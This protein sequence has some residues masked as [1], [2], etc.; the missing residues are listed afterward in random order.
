MSKRTAP[1]YLTKAMR[2]YAGAQPQKVS[3]VAKQYGYSSGCIVPGCKLPARIHHIVARRNGGTNEL[4]NLMPMCY[5][6]E[7]RVH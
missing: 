7:S 4:T 1:R 5:D 3:R 6:H 2:R